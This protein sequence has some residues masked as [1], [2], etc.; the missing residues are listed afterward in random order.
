MDELPNRR[1]LLVAGLL[2]GGVVLAGMT[3]LGGQTSTILSKVGAAIG[4]P[5]S[6]QEATETDRTAPQATA[7]ATGGQLAGLA[8]LPPK[9]LIV[10][11]GTIDVEV[12]DL[13]AAIRSAD[14]T[15]TRGGGYVDGSNRTAGAVAA[16][17]IVA[18]RIPSAAWEATL[19]SIHALATR[20]RDEQIKSVEVSAQVVDLGARIANL[21]TTEAAL[22]AIMAKATKISDVLA[23]QEQLTT[24]RDEIE[25]LVA[26]KADLED[27]ASFGSL[28]VSFRL[29]AVVAP[30][31]T[32]IASPGWNPASDVA[33]AT[34]KLVVI[35]QGTT[36]LGIWLGIVGLPLLIGGSVIAFVTV[37]LVR[38]GRWL[39]VRRGIVARDAS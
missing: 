24:T 15:V 6:G 1:V 3:L 23:V 18:Y 14:A 19:D 11:T 37:Q 31:A 34:D 32:P 13:D 7:T 12:A 39:L 4:T 26:G 29:P 30:T 16:T 22:Q 9:L 5:G 36:S 38:L 8:A 10:R 28:T 2:I 35:G 21:R 20:I 25:R 33:H 27:R 17:A